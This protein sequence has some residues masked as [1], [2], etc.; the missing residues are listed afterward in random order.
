MNQIG[1]HRRQPISMASAS[2]IRSLHCGLYVTGFAHPFEKG[3]QFSR[4][5][6]GDST[7]R[8]PITGMAATA[9]APRAAEAWMT[10]RAASSEMNSRRLMSH[11]VTRITLS[12]YRARTF[13]AILHR[14]LRTGPSKR[15]GIARIRT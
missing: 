12:Q 13:A 15:A 5:S 14:G 1:R 3:R 11:P 2:D 9:R 8:N 4:V 7:L 10:R 6:L